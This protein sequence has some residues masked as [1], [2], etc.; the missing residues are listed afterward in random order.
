MKLSK[1]FLLFAVLALTQICSGQNSAPNCC[2]EKNKLLPH[3][4]EG[5]KWELIWHDE[6]CGEKLDSSKWEKLGDFKRRDGWWVKEDTYLDGKGN[7]VLRTKKDGQHYTSGAIRSYGKF[8]HKFGY[9]L[10]RV[11]F[12]TQQGHWPGYWL[13][14]RPGVFS[15]GDEGRDGTEIDIMEKASLEDKITHTL[16]WDGYGEHHGMAIKYYEKPGLSKGFHTFGLWWKEN[17]Y[18]FYV[19][20][21]E[22]WRTSAGG[23]SQVP[24]YIKFSLE[25]AEFTGDITKADLPDYF[26]VDYMRVYDVTE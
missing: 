14:A 6:F 1:L 16:H 13:F 8:E 9:W 2:K 19:D 24:E 5:K 25:I 3:L 17:E 23:V 12:P 22:T 20:G 10:A 21:K 15:I 26:I 18:I 7:L 11:K 4:P